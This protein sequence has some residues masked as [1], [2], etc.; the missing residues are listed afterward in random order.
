VASLF[1]RGSGEIPG[2]GA[3]R[4]PADTGGAS[5]P[6][7]RAPFTGSHRC[8]K[9]EDRGGSVDSGF[10]LDANTV[11]I[12]IGRSECDVMLAGPQPLK[13]QWSTGMYL[14]ETRQ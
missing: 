4:D 7:C 2:A 3:A 8:Q 10:A 11:M 6:E 13:R 1:K 12:N 14:T 9:P 5:R